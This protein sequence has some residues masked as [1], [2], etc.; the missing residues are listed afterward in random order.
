MTAVAPKT[1]QPRRPAT[2]PGSMNSGFA[3]SLSASSSTLGS[4]P[5]R[6][7]PLAGP[8]LS[9][10]P[11]RRSLDGTTRGGDGAIDH[12]RTPGSSTLSFVGTSS[13]DA[14]SSSFSLVSTSKRGKDGPKDRNS[15]AMSAFNFFRRPSST[16]GHSSTGHST[17]SHSS[18]S[19]TTHSSTFTHSTSSTQLTQCSTSP[20]DPAFPP[21]A[22][23]HSRTES[24]R[25]R[26][27]SRPVSFIDGGDPTSATPKP[28][29]VAG[30]SSH[31]KR[32]FPVVRSH[33]STP[34][35]SPSTYRK[36]TLNPNAHRSRT[37]TNA[38][39]W[40]PLWASV[41]S[42]VPTNA[43][44]ASVPSKPDGATNTTDK[45]P[46]GPAEIPRFSRASLKQSGVVMPISAKDWRR[47]RSVA[48]PD[49]SDSS[50]SLNARSVDKGKG[51]ER[52]Q[53]VSFVDSSARG[54]KFSQVPT[55][56]IVPPDAHVEVK[57][58]P[59]SPTSDVLPSEPI[60]TSSTTAVK[61]EIAVTPGIEQQTDPATS[62]TPSHEFQP[63]SP[64]S[65]TNS[66]FSCAS[67]ASS[68]T[69]PSP[70]SLPIPPPSPTTSSSLFPSSDTSSEEKEKS[71]PPVRP[72]PR[73]RR[74]SN[75][76]SMSAGS[77][78]SFV[79]AMIRLSVGSFGSFATAQSGGSEG[80]NT[81][82]I[83]GDEV[84]NTDGEERVVLARTRSLDD[85]TSSPLLSP[86][87]LP[88]TPVQMREHMIVDVAHVISLPPP[89]RFPDH[90]PR[91]VT[92]EWV[93]GAPRGV[94]VVPNHTVPSHAGVNSDDRTSVVSVR[95]TG[96]NES[97]VAWVSNEGAVTEAMGE[98][99]KVDAQDQGK[100][101]EQSIPQMPAQASQTMKQQPQRKR[102]LT[103]SR[104]ASIV[105]SVYPPDSSSTATTSTTNVEP[106]SGSVPAPSTMTASAGT[107]HAPLKHAPTVL[108]TIVEDGS[109]HGHG[110]S[111]NGHVQ[112]QERV[113]ANGLPFGKDR[114]DNAAGHTV[115]DSSPVAE[116]DPAKTAPS[117]VGRMPPK[118]RAPDVKDIAVVTE[119]VVNA[120][121]KASST[122]SNVNSR[123]RSK[124]YS[125]LLPVLSFGKSRSKREVRDRDGSAS[126]ANVTPGTYQAGVG[127]GD[128]VGVPRK[129]GK[130]RKKRDSDA[131]AL[132]AVPKVAD[133]TIIQSAPNTNNELNTHSDT[134][135][136]AD[137]NITTL[138]QGSEITLVASPSLY[139][140]PSSALPFTTVSPPSLFG[141]APGSAASSI[142]IPATVQSVNPIPFVTE[143]AFATSTAEV[144]LCVDEP[145][146]TTANDLCLAHRLS[147]GHLSKEA[148]QTIANATA[149]DVEAN[150]VV[151]GGLHPR[152]TSGLLAPPRPGTS[153][154][155]LTT[156]SDDAS[157][158]TVPLPN[159]WD[160][161]AVPSPVRLV[162][163]MPQLQACHSCP[164]C[165]RSSPPKVMSQLPVQRHVEPVPTDVAAAPSPAF[166]SQ[167]S[168]PEMQTPGHLQKGTVP[169]ALVSSPSHFQP[170]PSPSPCPSPASIHTP[171]KLK[172]PQTLPDDIHK[173]G[174]PKKVGRGKGD[175][176]L[177]ASASAVYLPVLPKVERESKH[178][179]I[180]GLVAPAAP[181]RA[182][183][184]PPAMNF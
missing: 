176:N 66:F 7:S 6:S 62:A 26:P 65:S 148:V 60:A 11:S 12:S 75:P 17:A 94:T 157:F 134:H 171:R 83:E 39:N 103:K 126:S 130:M 15:S 50:N 160:G 135:P 99:A 104:P 41:T 1:R 128:V 79:D 85:L 116:S 96:A 118:G 139:A 95:T 61:P 177:D 32:P 166:A 72:R 145:P 91:R 107:T 102:K 23:T 86:P 49:P 44:K 124:R 111:S 78:L 174:S 56:Q 144:V 38:D 43:P 52:E 45:N 14:S 93:G 127:P 51:K 42:T 181:Q 70:T 55:V 77:R 153:S 30:M 146:S 37:S 119:M 170:S 24:L 47:R 150:G 20:T 151:N 80:E 73:N 110:G 92:A 25:S 4:R 175:G 88:P 90:P 53:R 101:R 58:H 122:P 115:R 125:F 169:R 165:G 138:P 59:P 64:K 168:A 152:L 147:H 29:S 13:P 46:F 179:S 182:A 89:A 34:T 109:S 2:A 27:G 178:L 22:L 74:Q 84:R 3:P 137:A 129:V 121:S 114:N 31:V 21:P 172:R 149:T 57:V 16:A 141:S 33:S 154:S 133:A 105:S 183:V 36:S 28:T 18:S 123:P 48:L 35:A 184:S 143:D 97:R 162:T 54:S 76:Q 163:P 108:S 161:D 120:P 117:Q 100:D 10:A 140:S 156:S 173:R 98:N 136:N 87:P 9:R 5:L 81:S 159:P 67:D 71:Y 164:L 8:A 132:S 180:K 82:E 113:D 155:T 167:F 63:L 112:A 19:A 158:L 131:P 106:G 142:R 69:P 68:Q 40:N